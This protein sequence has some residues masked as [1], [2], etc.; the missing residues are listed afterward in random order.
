MTQA[1]S[2][3]LQVPPEPYDLGRQEEKL[4][5]ADK[6]PRNRLRQRNPPP[7]TGRSMGARERIHRLMDAQGMTR[8]IQDRACLWVDPG[9]TAD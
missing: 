2:P 4:R 3:V 9:S 5:H 7:G 6:T 1:C 8:A